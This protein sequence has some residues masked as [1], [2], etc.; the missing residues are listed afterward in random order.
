MAS[1]VKEEFTTPDRGALHSAT[2]E[3]AKNGSSATE[4]KSAATVTPLESGTRESLAVEAETRRSPVQM[5]PTSNVDS[6]EDKK[7]HFG[8]SKDNPDEVEDSPSSAGSQRGLVSRRGGRGASPGRV[9]TPPSKENVLEFKAYRSP[10]RK[11]ESSDAVP[12][13]SSDT[14]PE[15]RAGKEDKAAEATS[16]ND[17]EEPAADQS[18]KKSKAADKKSNVTFSPVPPSRD[19]L[20]TPV[21]SPTGGRFQS[22]P[23][24]DDDT[25]R[26]PGSFLLTP[27]PPTPSKHTRAS[28]FDAADT[29]RAKYHKDDDKHHSRQPMRSPKTPRS[30][31]TPRREDR[32][33]FLTTPTDFSLDYGKHP[34]SG[35]FDSSNVLALLASP[36]ANGLFSPGG[37]AS[38]LNTPKGAPRTPRTPTVSTSF[39]FSDVAGLPRSAETSPK[40]DAKKGQRGV[41][42]IICISP[43]ASSK[44]KTG[45][46]SVYTPTINYK[47]M[48]ASPEKSAGLPLLGDSPLKGSK[49]RSQSASHD[50]SVDALHM[51]ERELREDE[52][53]SFLLQMNSSTPR[54]NGERPVAVSTSE[55][56]HVFRSPRRGKEGEE[57]DENVHLQLPVIGGGE[58][59]KGARLARKTQSR[60]HA[61]G[62]HFH[63][64]LSMRTASAEGGH[65]KGGRGESEKD[66]GKD[67]DDKAPK[68]S[69]LHPSHPPYGIPPHPYG[70]PDA[71]YY[72]SIPPGMPHGGSMRV[73]VGG[74]PPPRSKASPPRSP[75][76]G[77][78][79][80]LGP[81]DPA[82]PPPPYYPHHPGVPPPHMHPHYGH[83]PPAH[84]APPPR[85]MP[86]YG[87]QH[88]TGKDKVSKKA[89]KPAKAGA[90]RP[91]APTQ[92]KP[93]QASKKQKKSSPTAAP[94]KK[95][96]SPQITDKV[97]RQ[98]A[99][100]TIKAVNE[101]SGGKNDKAA[102]LAAAILRG[103]TMR[104]SGKWQAQ[105][106]FAGKS[107]YIGVFDTREKAALAY[108]I[109]REKL[110][111]EKQSAE[112]GALSAKAT[113]AAVNAARKAA[114]EGVN[115]RDPRVEGD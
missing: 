57:G 30:P 18:S 33:R 48:F 37:F 47:S 109:A 112:G 95:N 24:L 9:K 34:H 63:R 40:P 115:E 70:H 25:L 114:F 59:G 6:P 85:H 99:A 100:A 8:G 96:R 62:E 46:S 104:P 38:M 27:H 15:G 32:E 80:A 105:L 3:E 16:K 106:Y 21:K 64:S 28:S 87:A 89:S 79:Y 41:S 78:P 36:T 73:V 76:G 83:Y 74:P 20:R 67:S 88:P 111:A 77:R 11:S 102:A 101:A 107:R 13:L 22:L 75:R 60:D 56:T 82:Y 103:V 23:L 58:S 4:Q 81:G 31:R 17:E 5:V 51:A 71:A 86:M 108:E 44:A 52:D 2:A 113:E 55:G 29:D 90:K 43:L 54:A 12:P 61:E 39:F 35:S 110:K 26:S 84:H 49:S 72:A 53:L 94:K 45:S 91:L 93:L 7:V 1:V 92:D 68:V 10:S 14:S 65:A 97:E 19:H 50:P 66:G 69:S 98:K 42:N